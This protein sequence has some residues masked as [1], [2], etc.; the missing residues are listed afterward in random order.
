MPVQF[1]SAEK[2]WIDMSVRFR[3]YPLYEMYHNGNEVD[4]TQLR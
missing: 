1:N 4:T 3:P 2:S